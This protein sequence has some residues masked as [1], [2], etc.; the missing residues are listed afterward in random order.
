MERVV[1]VP[2]QP[3]RLHGWHLHGVRVHPQRERPDRPL[4]LHPGRRDP[5]T[6]QTDVYSQKAADFIRRRAPSKKPFYLSVAPRDPHSEAASCNCAGNNP[7]AAP[8][9][10]GKLAGPDG[11]AGPQLQRGE[12]FR[13]ALQH[14]ESQSAHPAQIAKR[15][16]PLPGSGRGGAGSRRSRP[17]RRQHSQGIG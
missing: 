13:Q 2:R 8:R 9:Y 3:G 15:G 11:P 14:Q 12:R 4:R 7:R 17:E 1:R 10:E 16:R 6:Y 5:A